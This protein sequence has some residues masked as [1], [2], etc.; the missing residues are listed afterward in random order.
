MIYYDT[1]H[2][3][4]MTDER[5]DRYLRRGWYRI[6]QTVITTDLITSEGR[7]LPVFWLR[8]DLRRFRISRSA[9]RILAK[10]ADLPVRIADPVIGGE[11]EELYAAYRAS[12]DFTIPETAREYLMGDRDTNA[13]DTSLIEVR[14]RGRLAA[15]GFFDCGVESLA[16]V[17][18]LYRPEYRRTSPGKYLMLLEILIAMDRGMRYYYPGYVST[19]TPKYDYKLFPDPG[20]AEVF[21]RANDAWFPYESIIDELREWSVTATRVIN[22]PRNS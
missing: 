7:L 22:A 15:A 14:D 10:N 21:I 3:V 16:G 20:S 5:M 2:P 19:E 13:Y 17:L 12:I 18:H 11:I 9:R 1:E 4:T 6:Q 8:L